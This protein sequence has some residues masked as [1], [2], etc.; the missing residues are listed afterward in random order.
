MA[1]LPNSAKAKKSVS[2][3]QDN[4]TIKTVY[5]KQMKTRR[6]VVTVEGTTHQ[7]TEDVQK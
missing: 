2:Y 6:N 7:M 1:T 3:V 5:S 4:T